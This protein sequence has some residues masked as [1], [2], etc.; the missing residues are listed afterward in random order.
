MDAKISICGESCASEASQRR[1]PCA[2]AAR[3]Q[4]FACS[5]EASGVRRRTSLGVPT[6][7]SSLNSLYR[8]HIGFR[9]ATSGRVGEKTKA[10]RRIVLERALRDLVKSGM[11][12]RRIGNLKE[13]HVRRVLDIWRF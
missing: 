6:L 3:K 13:K 8:S 10:E 11:K 12:L 2:H 9:S 7:W 1:S 5:P 4:P